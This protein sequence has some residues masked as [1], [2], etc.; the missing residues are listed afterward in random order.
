LPGQRYDFIIE[1]NADLKNGSNF[2]IH[3]QYC[4]EVDLLPN[5]LGILRYDSNDKSDPYTPPL[6]EQ[7]RDY[8]CAD[9]DPN[10][11]VPVVKQS[12]GQR[13]NGIEPKDYLLLGEQGWPDPAH[14]PLHK[15]IIKDVPMWLDWTDPTLKKLVLDDDPTFPPETVPVYLDYE[16]DTWVY[17]IISANYSLHDITP[18][19]ELTPSVHPIHLH[20]H[21]FNI[22]AQGKGIFPPDVVPNLE[23]PARRDVIDIDIGGWA[24]IAFQINNPGAWLLHCHLAFHTSDGLALQFIEQPSKIKGLVE[25]A[26]ILDGF[27]DNC[28]AWTDW[29]NTVNVPN[30]ATQAD[31]GV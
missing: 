30:N 7:H 21:D 18:V 31:S 28:N 23:N 4:N 29:Y 25:G 19:R 12:V 13:I 22:L 5:K 8:G 16:T 6:S 27:A 10:Q 2:W 14:P 1:T 24:W 11:L 3:A 26:G 15:W 9:P 17:F 20:G